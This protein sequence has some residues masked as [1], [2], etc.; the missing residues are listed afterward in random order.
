MALRA[1][2]LTV[3]RL[4]APAAAL[5]LAPA[6]A[7]TA[8]PDLSRL[9]LP[10]GFSIEVWAD[11]LANAR[12]MAMGERGT[13]FVGTRTA[14]NVYAVSTGAELPPKQRVLTRMEE[15]IHQFMLVTEGP[16]T[17]AGEV[18]FPIEGSK[19]ELGLYLVSNGLGRAYRLHIRGPSFVNMMA[20][21]PMSEGMLVSDLIAIV[22]SLD[23]VL[24]EVDR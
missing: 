19:G 6:V 18:Y 20:L 12:S 15:L 7:W 8:G 13:I 16:T 4:F 3:A 22:A 1:G 23:P 5:L 17:P 2:V 24:G 21:A 10:P 14:G 9:T 11:G